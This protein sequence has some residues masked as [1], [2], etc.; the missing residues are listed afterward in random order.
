[1][2]RINKRKKKLTRKKKVKRGGGGEKQVLD[3]DDEIINQIKEDLGLE[4]YQ[5][6]LVE[7]DYQKLKEIGKFVQ[8]Q[9]DYTR[10]DIPKKNKNIGT[11]K[12]L[13]CPNCSKKSIHYST[14][15]DF[16]FGLKGKPTAYYF[17]DNILCRSLIGVSDATGWL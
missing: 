7:K 13:T 3:F 10:W 6:L 14:T 15:G 8:S 9:Y 17:C 2:P 4:T 1:M 11:A 16:S 5:Q 12:N